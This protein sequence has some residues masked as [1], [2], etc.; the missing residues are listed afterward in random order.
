MVH[1]KSDAQLETGWQHNLMSA[2][3]LGHLFSNSTAHALK[4]AGNVMPA[5]HT[6]TEPHP[7]AI[8]A[9]NAVH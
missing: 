4:I 1:F 7:R 8:R 3:S 9:L 5:Y 2:N 6:G